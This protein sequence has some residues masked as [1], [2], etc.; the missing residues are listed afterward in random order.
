MFGG[1]YKPHFT[2]DNPAQEA[3]YR[4]DKLAKKQEAI[5]L[6]TGDKLSEVQLRGILTTI[7]GDGDAHEI[8]VVKSLLIDFAEKDPKK[9]IALTGL[10]EKAIVPGRVAERESLEVKAKILKCNI[11]MHN[12]KD[13]NLQS[14]V[15]GEI[16][17]LKT[18]LEKATITS[19]RKDEKRVCQ[20]NQSSCRP[21]CPFSFP[22]TS[23]LRSNIL[24]YA[25]SG[26]YR[27]RD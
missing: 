17:K 24:H 5:S 2:V 12:M 23:W 27:R 6:I 9:F 11:G 26:H 7:S 8:E 22:T 19:E 21:S 1:A 10:K 15:E 20:P 16:K 13:E 4:L 3:Q 14:K 18:E 25:I